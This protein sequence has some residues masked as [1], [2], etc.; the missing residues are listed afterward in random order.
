MSYEPIQNKKTKQN[1]QK[2]KHKE[3]KERKDY[4]STLCDFN[5]L[6]LYKISIYVMLPRKK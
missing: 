3:R 1:K 2:K 4:I 6:T 5:Y